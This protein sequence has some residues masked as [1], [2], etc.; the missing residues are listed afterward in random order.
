M[1]YRTLD[2]LV[3]SENDVRASTFHSRRFLLKSDGMGFSFHDTILFAGS[4]TYIWYANHL[5]A[6]YCIEGEGELETVDDGKI[7]PIHPGVFY[8]LDK[9]DKHYLRAKSQLRM[10]CVFNP[11]LTGREVHDEQGTYPLME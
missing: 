10:M 4:E 5:E 6:V 7:H 1:I 2:E 8:A 11:P 9:H 3:G